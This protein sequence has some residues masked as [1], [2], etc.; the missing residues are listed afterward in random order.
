MKT[1]TRQTNKSQNK[2]KSWLKAK[3]IR[4]S[5]NTIMIIMIR[6]IMKLSLLM[7]ITLIMMMMMAIMWP[8]QNI[9]TSLLFVVLIFIFIGIFHTLY[10]SLPHTHTIAFIELNIFV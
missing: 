1:T 2:Y 6:T 8:D 7:I 9:E 5:T 4:K 10:L 3:K